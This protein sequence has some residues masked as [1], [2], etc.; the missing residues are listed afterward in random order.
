MKSDET[1]NPP[2]QPTILIAEDDPDQSDML[3]ETLQEEGYT[4][5]TAFSGDVAYRKLLE[6]HYDLVILDIR[7]PGLDGAT[8]LKAY[9]LKHKLEEAPVLIVSAFATEPDVKRYR[10]AGANACLSKPY[11]I[12]ELLSV[13]AFLIPH[14][15]RS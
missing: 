6:R 2:Q 4:V 3:R 11:S 15:A 14:G 10:A 13:V 7:M 8:V 5:E 12:D 1:L 9:R